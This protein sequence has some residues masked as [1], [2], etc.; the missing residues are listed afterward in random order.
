ME[1]DTAFR[2]LADENF[3]GRILRG[4]L[5]RLPDLDVVRAQ[6]LTELS[7]SSDPVLLEWA[8]RD[9]RIVLSHDVETLAGYAYARLEAGQAM[10]GLF[11]LRPEVPIGI[12]IE[13]LEEVIALTRPEE[14]NGL[15]A[16][17]P[18]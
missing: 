9:G 2:L 4:L 15:V 12:A 16:F 11:E 3:N 13:A 1:T 6:D 7:G 10:P 5:R 8:A 14:W 18:L 17:L